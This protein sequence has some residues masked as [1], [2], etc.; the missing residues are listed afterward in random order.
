MPDALPWLLTLTA[1]A[2]GL[3]AFAALWMSL[4]LAFAD[5]TLDE[6]NAEVESEENVLLAVAVEVGEVERDGAL[7]HGNRRGRK[8]EWRPVGI[9]AVGNAVRV[10]VR[11][12]LGDLRRIV[13]A[14]G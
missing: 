1:A 12:P 6:V 4:R 10:A 2:S 5:P 9:T 8:R 14:S 3:F 13:D 11:C 7:D